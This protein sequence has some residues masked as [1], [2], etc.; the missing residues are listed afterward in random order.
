M[1]VASVAPLVDVRQVRRAFTR[2]AA[3]YDAAAVLQREI[4]ARML[5]RLDYVKIQPGTIIDLGC[6]TGASLA[7]LG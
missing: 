5:E 1:P 7:A 2:A 3:G 4:A 6:G